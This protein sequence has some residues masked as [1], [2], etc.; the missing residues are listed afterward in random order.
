MTSG[1]KG[2][3]YGERGEVRDYERKEK[4][5]RHGSGV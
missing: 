2:E 4:N 5:T 3:S 1:L